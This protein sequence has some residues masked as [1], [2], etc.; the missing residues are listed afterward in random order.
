MQ[1]SALKPLAIPLALAFTLALPA[2]AADSDSTEPGSKTGIDRDTGRLR[3]T[4]VAEDRALE[5]DAERLRQSA[6]APAAPGVAG[7][8]RPATEAE[9]QRTLV[10]HADGTVSMLV[11][12]SL[13]SQ[14]LATRDAQGNLVISHA[15]EAEVDHVEE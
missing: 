11:P 13:D 8:V 5:R 10:R 12:E 15:G 4:T 14:V 2:H 7:L 6:R 3:A 1:I 9:A